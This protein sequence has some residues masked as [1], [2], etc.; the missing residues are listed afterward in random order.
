MKPPD[1]L[2]V[3]VRFTEFCERAE[4]RLRR[5]LTAGY[6]IDVG[7]AATVDA[8]VYGWQHWARIEQ[9]SNPV[10]YLF[11]VG[12]NIAKRASEYR[13]GWMTATTTEVPWI[14][15]GLRPAL[16]ALSERQRMVVALVHG[17]GMSFAEVAD[18]I[19]VSKSSVQTHERRAMKSL[20]RSLGVKA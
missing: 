3:E 19:G 14:E 4:P 5:A 13:A 8:L 18:L 17:M 9:M 6:G 11:R 12:Q 15:P 7:R 10:G 1:Q 16:A 20:R 2:D